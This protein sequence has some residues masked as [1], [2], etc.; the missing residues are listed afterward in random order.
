MNQINSQNKYPELAKEWFL[1]AQDDELSSKD[2][3]D[4]R[5]GSPNTVCF[6]SQQIAEKV[7]KA[8]L[9]FYGVEFPKVHQLDE[10]L[11]LCEKIDIEFNSL[12]DDAEDLTPFYIST[13][14][15]G[16]YPTYSFKDAEL[17]FQKA[18]E[19]KDFVL[20]RLAL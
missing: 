12:V 10:L 5:E 7:L 11:K 9:C 17:A 1:R 18:I 6:L 16:D 2:I 15:P 20:K 8:F 19:I 3:L 14:Y 4:D 13:R